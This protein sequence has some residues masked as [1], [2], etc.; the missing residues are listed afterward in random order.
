MA[1]RMKQKKS[2]G[3][4]NFQGFISGYRAALWVADLHHTLRAL[5]GKNVPFLRNLCVSAVNYVPSA[6]DFLARYAR[7]AT[8]VGQA[9][10]I[11]RNSSRNGAPRTSRPERRKMEKQSSEPRKQEPET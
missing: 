1:Q 10:R 3:E 4:K 7:Y 5:R 2:K 6:S 9:S 8:A 11:V